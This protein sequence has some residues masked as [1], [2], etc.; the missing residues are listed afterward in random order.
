MHNIILEFW[1]KIVFNL[2]FMIKAS[3]Y[4]DEIKFIISWL[5]RNLKKYIKENWYFNDNST[6]YVEKMKNR[7]KLFENLKEK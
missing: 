7:I 6:L 5:K 4:P 1:I 3:L 2:S